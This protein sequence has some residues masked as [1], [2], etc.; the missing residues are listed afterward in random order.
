MEALIATVV[1]IAALIAAV[2]F[3]RKSG[4]D[5]VER[6]NQSEVIDAVKQAKQVSE[7]VTNLDANAR[8]DKLRDSIK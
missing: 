1:V 3:G 5:S 6:E 8:R 4:A 2:I 7:V